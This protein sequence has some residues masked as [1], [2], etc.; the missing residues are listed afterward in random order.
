M[1]LNVR[2]DGDTVILS[3]FARLLNDPRHFDAARDVRELLDQGHKKFILELRGIRE[4][5]SA[6]L[7]L[8]TTLTRQIRQAGGDA[9]LASLSKDTAEYLETMRMDA[10]WDVYPSVADAREALD[11]LPLTRPTRTPA[12][13]DEPD[14][15]L[16]RGG[17]LE[18]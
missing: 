16:G 11:E 7:G 17:R 13:D 12:S 14:D 4:P 3:N 18:S 5:G 15:E 2:I 6:A 8:F 1:P 10:F 9:V